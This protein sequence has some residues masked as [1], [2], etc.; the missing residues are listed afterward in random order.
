[1]CVQCIFLSLSNGFFFS[2]S[3]VSSLFFICIGI[4]ATS[5]M[6]L[7]RLLAHEKGKRKPQKQEKVGNIYIQYSVSRDIDQRSVNNAMIRQRKI[8]AHHSVMDLIDKQKFNIKK[9]VFFCMSFSSS[10]SLNLSKKKKNLNKNGRIVN[11]S[12]IYFIVL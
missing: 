11:E 3:C 6:Q 4:A 7:C 8:T 10:L 9:F 1:M 12:P 5:V 2:H